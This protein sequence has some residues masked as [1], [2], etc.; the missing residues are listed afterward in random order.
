[1]AEEF[2]ARRGPVLEL[3]AIHHYAAAAG[4]TVAD[5]FAFLGDRDCAADRADN[6]LVALARN[7]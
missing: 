6:V 7:F 5:E 3:R 4:F 1:M 2:S